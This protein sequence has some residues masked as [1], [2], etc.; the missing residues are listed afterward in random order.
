ML[1]QLV[2]AWSMRER[3][4]TYIEVL[5]Q[6]N[7]SLS[8]VSLCPNH[9]LSWLYLDHPQFTPGQV[10]NL[11]LFYSHCLASTPIESFVHGPKGAFPKTFSKTLQDT[12]SQTCP[13][14][15]SLRQHSHSP[16]TLGPAQPSP[17]QP[18]PSSASL[19]SSPLFHS[20]AHVHVPPS[21]H[22]TA[23]L[24]TRVHEGP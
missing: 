15:A 12:V 3:T 20:H 8:N 24:L 21:S 23:D 22:S 18:P 4:K 1:R 14:Q 9:Q 7:F 16:S 2:S 6:I 17:S 13:T 19:V 11:Y 10:C 5:Q